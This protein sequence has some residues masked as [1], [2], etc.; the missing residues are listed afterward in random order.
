ME[1]W[2]GLNGPSLEVRFIGPVISSP[3]VEPRCV[4]L[5]RTTPSPICQALGSGRWLRVIV[6]DM[7]GLVPAEWRNRTGPVY[8]ITTQMATE[9][10]IAANGQPYA[11]LSPPALPP[12]GG[13]VNS[14]FID[15]P[16]I[17]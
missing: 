2:G 16:E 10:L 12:T 1:I 14:L 9:T 6:G 15:I 5:H 7:V 8:D 17:I 11:S 13:S 3:G 4:H